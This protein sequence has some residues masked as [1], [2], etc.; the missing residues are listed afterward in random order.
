[1]MA[2]C[3]GMQDGP[4]LNQKVKTGSFCAHL[5]DLGETDYFISYSHDKNNCLESAAAQASS[6]NCTQQV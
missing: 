3:D 6:G 4:I 5:S 2:L 1:M